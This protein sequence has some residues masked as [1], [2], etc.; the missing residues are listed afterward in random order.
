MRSG[1]EQVELYV[2]E[3]VTNKHLYRLTG[4]CDGKKLFSIEG[5][6]LDGFSE[7]FALNSQSS[8]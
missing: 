8:G 7:W 2:L 3:L 1:G 4:M 6:S 5:F